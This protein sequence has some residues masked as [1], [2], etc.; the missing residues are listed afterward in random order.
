MAVAVSKAWDQEFRDVINEDIFPGM[1]HRMNIQGWSRTGKTT[2]TCELLN[3]EHVIFHRNLEL[4]DFIGGWKLVDGTMVW[5]DGPAVRAMRKGCC[6]LIDEFNNIPTEC[7]TYLYA[8]CDDPAW[9]TLPN[10]ELVKAQPGYCVVATMNPSPDVLPHPLYDRFDIY[11]KADRLSEGVKKALGEFAKNAEAVVGYGQPKL[12]WQRPAT[13]NAF[14]AANKMRK[15]GVRDERIAEV[16]GW[17]G[18]QATD[19]M[20]A[21]AGK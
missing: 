12:D 13:V 2:L 17:Y 8:I 3:P 9:V 11:L 21:C 14:L 19:F 15:H 10:G 16:L 18:R 20:T 4:V 5:V 1:I 6:L 7:E